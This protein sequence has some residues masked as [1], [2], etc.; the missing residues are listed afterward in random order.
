MHDEDEDVNLDDDKKK[1]QNLVVKRGKTTCSGTVEMAK[2]KA[3]RLWIKSTLYR[4]IFS[5]YLD[6][7]G[8]AIRAGTTM[9]K[10]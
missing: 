9:L 8:D 3:L 5:L 10:T 7:P 6:Q 1:C 2:G 4:S